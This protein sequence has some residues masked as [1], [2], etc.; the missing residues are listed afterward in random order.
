ME[1]QPQQEE[2]NKLTPLQKAKN[3][4]Y[5]KNRM[6]LM[7]KINEIN[8]T[9]YQTDD[10]FRE[11]VCGYARKYYDNNKDKKKAYYLKKKLEKQQQ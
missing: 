6:V 5:Q 2:T 8:K 9:K 4:Y 3:K 11:K 10:N 1:I 7:H